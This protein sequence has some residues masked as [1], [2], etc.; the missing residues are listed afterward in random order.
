LDL[1]RRRIIVLKL[2]AGAIAAVLFHF[3]RNL[4]L[5]FWQ[6]TTMFVTYCMI[7]QAQQILMSFTEN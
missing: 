3:S 6:K 1:F 4:G 7:N 5:N 2:L